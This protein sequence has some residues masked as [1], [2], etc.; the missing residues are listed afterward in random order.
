MKFLM[1]R[2]KNKKKRIFFYEKVFFFVSSPLSLNRLEINQ[3]FEP[4]S[5]DKLLGHCLNGWNFLVKV[6]LKLDVAPVQFLYPA[7]FSMYFSEP[8]QTS[9]IPYAHSFYAF[10]Y[11]F[12][13][14]RSR[15]FFSS[16][17]H[18]VINFFHQ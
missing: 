13:L 15:Y 16:Q 10:F 12:F 3:L 5:R 7:H 17:S 2:E 18:I 6:S 11:T 14:Y 8:I 4:N 1:Q 9:Y